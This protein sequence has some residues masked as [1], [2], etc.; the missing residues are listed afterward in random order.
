MEFYRN[1]NVFI[2]WRL[3]SKEKV[4]LLLFLS[5]ETWRRLISRLVWMEVHIFKYDVTYAVRE[6]MFGS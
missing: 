1:R 2:L 4:K 6:V 5:N 3:H